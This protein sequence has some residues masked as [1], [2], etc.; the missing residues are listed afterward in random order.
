MAKEI[1]KTKSVHVE[2]NIETKR[3]DLLSS[4]AD[5]LNKKNKEGG[6]VAFFLDEQENPADI[7]DWISTGSSL[8]DLAISNRPNGGLPVSKMVEFSGLEGTGKSLLSA[9][10][11]AN[12]QKKGGKAIMIDTENSAAPEF[13]KSLGVDL[14]NLLYIQRETVE[15]IFGTIES[16]I[17][18]IRKNDT[19]CLVTIIVDSVAAASTKTEQESEHGKTGYATDKSIIISKAMRKIT[20]MIGR[21][22][23]LIVFTNQLRQNINAMA[24]GDKWV[25]SGGK[26]IA[27]HTSV[28]VRLNNMGKLKKGDVV[29]GNGC[30]A[31]VVKNRMGPP[32]RDAQF[33]IYYDSGIAD[34]SSWLKILKESNLIKQA[35]AYYKYTTD[36]GEEIQFQSKDFVIQMQN[37]IQLKDELYNKICDK[38]IMKYKD[39]NSVIVEDA[40]VETSEEDAGI[41]TENA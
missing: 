33:D 41:N 23:V 14:K 10:I 3:D 1:K 12:T 16:A 4:L 25:I 7:P 19:D 5:E 2:S 9:H 27:Y 15:D 22:K 6:K 38:V 26:A 31:I 32:N 37:N 24:F 11:I 21:Q 20:T 40:T 35:G 8:L 39:P 18:Y 13:W 34:Y 30:K 29:I 28:R 36:A 17:A